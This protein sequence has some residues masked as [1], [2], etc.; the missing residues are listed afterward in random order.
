MQI[1]LPDAPRTDIQTDRLRDLA[2]C[3]AVHQLGRSATRIHHQHGIS[4]RP[5]ARDG[6]VERQLRLLLPADQ[7]RVD[8]QPFSH[9][10]KEDLPIGRV[11]GRRCR[12]EASP[13][14]PEPLDHRQVF[15]DDRPAALHRLVRELPGGVHALAQPREPQ[16]PVELDQSSGLVGR[17]DQQSQ[18]VRAA[19]QCGHCLSHRSS[20]PH[21]RSDPKPGRS[22]PSTPAPRPRSDSP[23][24][25]QPR[26]AR[27]AHAGTSPGSACRRR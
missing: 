21:R 14:G 12:H 7:F 17:R 19:I 5:G 16:L 9:A 13:G 3:G 25:R 15:V 20:L 2:G 26:R 4:V 27:P 1:P 18:G 24:V 10:V 6:P 23:R 22:R 8:A 11:A